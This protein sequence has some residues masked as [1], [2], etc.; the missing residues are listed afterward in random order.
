[1]K[2]VHTSD[3]HLG[4]SFHREPLL[5]HQA[6]YLDHLVGLVRAERADAVLVAGDVYDRAVPPV[7]AVQ[8]LS[9]TLRR[10]AERAHVV[11]ISGNHDSAAR[12]GFGA[13]VMRPELH[14]VTALEAVGRV[15]EIPCHDGSAGLVYPFPFLDVDAARGPLAEDPAEPLA[16]SHA[17][18]LAAAMRRARADW[19]LRGRPRVPVVVM[20]H[21]FVT[22]GEPSES[23][24]DIR[25][26]GVDAVPVGVVVGDDQATGADY[27]ALGHLHRPQ[28]VDTGRPGRVARYAGSPLAFSFSEAGQVKSTAV[29]SIGGEDPT[30]RVELVPA[31]VPRRLAEAEGPLADLLS[32]AYD[33]VVDTWVKVT[34]TDPVRPEDLTRVVKARFPHALV[35][36][37][38]PPRREGERVGAVGRAR[39]PLDVAREFVDYAG[40]APP[41]PAEDNALAQ[42]LEAVRAAERSA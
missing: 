40:G 31:P 16:R 15:V 38:V 36:Q 32:P 35:V 27:V 11:V 17:A 23:E 21:A 18:V 25:V 33:D 8:L 13:A 4:R 14:L 30:P 29:V 39:D 10:L 12:L 41:T 42:S 1:V 7:E 19:D 5:G 24:R 3:W 34:V 22:G 37:H 20:A 9:E 2:V 28:R 26:G 6:V